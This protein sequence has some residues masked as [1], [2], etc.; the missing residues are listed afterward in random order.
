MKKKLI[1]LSVFVIVLFLIF[2]SNAIAS[3]E[4]HLGDLIIENSQTLTL[5][6]KT[7]KV[8]GNFILNEGATLN[9]ENSTLIIVERYKS[10]HR[11]IATSAHIKIVNS[12]IRSSENTMVEKMGGFLGSELN[13]DI[14]E[15]NALIENSNI[16]GRIS[17]R[18]YSMNA[19]NS[20][21]SF[22]YWNYNSD[23]EI[24]DSLIGSFVFDCKDSTPEKLTL[25][26]LEKDK[27]INLNLESLSLGSIKL[28]NS[29]VKAMWSFNFDYACQKD[30]T[31]KNS[32]VE[33][34]WIKFP[35][36]DTRI[37][38][39]GLP[40]GF[41]KEFKL[42]DSVSGIN[43][44]Y[45]ITLLNVNFNNFKPEMLGTIAEISNSYA[46]V[47]PY[48]YSDLIIKNSIL[49]NMFNY[50]SKRIEF[51][52]TILIQSMQLIHKPEFADG[53]KVGNKTIG[54]G[55]YF[56]FIFKNSSID[57]S[58]FVIADYRGTIQGDVKILEPKNLDDVHWIKGIIIREYS[59][60]AEPNTEI[61]LL[62]GNNAIFLGK[63]DENGKTFFNI[64]F[65]NETYR[66]EFELETE[67]NSR[68]VNF[69]TDT[70]IIFEKAVSTTYDKEK[71]SN[72]FP[73]LIILIVMGVIV[74][75]L[76]ILNFKKK[77][78]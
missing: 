47:H 45:N 75:F 56:N 60:I 59:V 72:K 52:D 24:N 43:L 44:P 28:H 17:G 7:L 26:N 73:I 46:M 21:I 53:F 76:I 62:E 8:D 34:F 4:V 16:Y 51:I 3:A 29:S 5:K 49:I 11:F 19:K 2:T 63:T 71:K 64:T 27:N 67:K 42:Q 25:E 12:E 23:I 22:V 41:V 74:V 6:D 35:P 9:L 68:K 57:V 58:P 38:I 30:I 69:L 32:E 18:F 10:E 55:G 48:D 14:R 50:G 15:A 31:V 37:K 39:N 61:I 1:L 20:T 66:R 65:N 70:P 77:K 54:E 78:K 40:T 36:T 33:N 13:I